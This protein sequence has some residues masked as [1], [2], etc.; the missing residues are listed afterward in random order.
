MQILAM[1]ALVAAAEVHVAPLG[2]D[3]N[4]GTEAAP[5]ATIA[6]AVALAEPGAE[7]IVHGGT[8]VIEMPV[9]LDGTKS[10]T[11]KAPTVIRAAEGAEVRIAGGRSIDPKAFTTD[12]PESGAARVAAEAKGQVYAADLAALGIT[13]FGD[14][15]DAFSVV[16]VVMELFFNDTRMTLARWP[17]E[18]W[19]E[20][21][22]VVESGPAPWRNHESDA[23]GV[24]AYSGDRPE[25][26]AN[27][28]AVWLEGYWCFD[29][30]SEFIKV[31]EIDTEKKRITLGTQHV[32]GLGSG[33]P[34]GRR[35]Y[36]VNLL[37]ELDAPGE[38]YIDREGAALYFWPPG[39]MEGARIVVSEIAEPM[40]RIA[41]AAHVRIEGLTFETCQ[42][43]AVAVDGGS[44]VHI[45][46]CTVRNTGMGAIG[47]Q[48]GEGHRVQACHIHDTGTTGI[49]MDGGDRKT[50]TPA[51]HLA[52]NN[53]IHHFS[54]RQR[55]YAP[56]LQVGGVGNRIA[57]NLL[58]DAPHMAIG[59]A[60]NDHIVEY[61][62]VHHVIL[63]TDD[64]GALYTGRN[65]S[66]RGT[67]I[68]Y[69]YWWEIG[70]RDG[71]G[72]NAIYFDDGDGGQ[73][74]FG[75]VF[76]RCG[77]PGKGGM[78]AVFNHGGH[79][80]LIDNN[81]FIECKRAIGAAPWGDGTWKEW[82]EGELWHTRL[83]EE[84]DITQPPF[85]TR[86]P[87]LVGFFELDGR[88]RMNLATRNI[89]VDC[90]EF[91]R[92]NFEQANNW[93]TMTEDPGFADREAFDFTLKKK[94]ASFEKVPG[95]EPIPFAAI[96]LRKDAYR[97]EAEP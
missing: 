20:I 14:F 61:N 83:R 51:G 53:H 6:R 54:R 63:E 39:P 46:N 94:A 41:G 7:V 90:G 85:T 3:G 31:K 44:G 92:G 49:V 82:V 2:D 64:C 30:R 87:E 50:L 88:P 62:E 91:A 67:I 32:Y 79:G 43:D 52:D 8:Y 33:N 84:V 69:N 4:M 73:T 59:V 38:Y 28:P 37:E 55:T 25:R 48:G 35:Y 81:L 22:E 11:A 13:N 72:N 78:A 86:Y 58:H 56:A 36:A 40:L 42:G 47:I 15:P 5:V 29:W 80:N 17:N 70:A 1:L 65:P 95:F 66:N 93:V 12:L 89:A 76:Y 27:A 74:V 71:H 77:N 60:G 23:L 34:G 96:G 21:A 9:I 97:E 19:T 16:P 24:F 45:A 26:W 75:N 57:H 10:G 18:D 68:R